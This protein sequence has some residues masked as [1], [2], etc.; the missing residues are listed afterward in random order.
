MPRCTSSGPSAIR[1][2]RAIARAKGAALVSYT[3]L[4]YTNSGTQ[5]IRAA[6]ILWALTGNLDVPGGTAHIQGTILQN[7]GTV[8]GKGIIPIP[9]GLVQAS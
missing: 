8:H 4:E 9:L 3:G 2:A 6:L 1:S 7:K 5:N